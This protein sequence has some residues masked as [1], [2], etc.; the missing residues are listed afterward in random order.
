LEVLVAGFEA[1][2]LDDFSIDFFHQQV[3][4]FDIPQTVRFFD[5]LKWFRPSS[6]TLEFYQ[7]LTA[8][9]FFSSNTIR[10]S[11][12]PRSWHIDGKGLDW[13]VAS[14][15]QICSQIIPLRSSV[16]SLIIKCGRS[17]WPNPNTDMD[18]TLWLQLFHL[19]P[20]VRSLS[21]H[22]ELEPFIAVALQRAT[23]ESAAEVFPLLRSLYITGNKSGKAAQQGIQSFIA[24]RQH[25]GHP[26]D[27][28]P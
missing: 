5:H 7:P 18:S 2:L 10:H 23:G 24:D 17:W 9:I 3:I 21:I 16:E 4:D 25:S 6:L 11:L 8:S 15:A 14:V 27:L 1:P 13:K 20:S 28:L 26:V 12:S 22:V 19:F